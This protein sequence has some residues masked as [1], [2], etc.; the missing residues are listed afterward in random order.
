MLPIEWHHC[1]WMIYKVGTFILIYNFLK[2]QPSTILE[3]KKFKIL[4]FV[5]LRQTDKLCCDTLNH[6]GEWRFE[7]LLKIA[8]SDVT[9][10]YGHDTI[11][12]LYGIIMNDV[13][14]CEVNWWRFVT[15]FK[16]N[17]I[18]R[19]K[20]SLLLASARSGDLTVYAAKCLHFLALHHGGQ[21]RWHR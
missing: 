8:W 21:N 9:V 14:L 15:L 16:Y 17:W 3:F 7:K 18:D 10:I 20:K 6:C 11:R 19:F 5:V 4:S 1:P 12:M 13:I 2:I